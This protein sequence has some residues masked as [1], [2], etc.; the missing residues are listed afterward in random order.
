[1]ANSISQGLRQLEEQIA[2]L[3]SATVDPSVETATRLESLSQIDA[4]RATYEDLQGRTMQ[5]A[6]SATDRV[7]NDLLSSLRDINDQLEELEIRRSSLMDRAEHEVLEKPAF[8]KIQDLFRDSQSIFNTFCQRGQPVSSE[9]LKNILNEFESTLVGRATDLAA[10]ASGQDA[11]DVKSFFEEKEQLHVR[12]FQ[13]KLEE[14]QGASTGDFHGRFQTLLPLLGE[15]SDFNSGHVFISEENHAALQG[16]AARISGELDMLIGMQEE[17]ENSS[18]SSTPVKAALVKAVQ[19][20]DNDTLKAL[21]PQVSREIREAFF[22]KLNELRVAAHIRPLPL[23]T[24]GFLNTGRGS[25][26][27]N[28]NSPELCLQA[29]EA[30]FPADAAQEEGKAEGM[31]EMLEAMKLSMG[32]GPSE[33][34]DTTE[35]ALA[36]ALS[37]SAQISSDQ[38]QLT[39]ALRLVQ[40]ISSE[41]QSEANSAAQA[42]QAASLLAEINRDLAQSKIELTKTLAILLKGL[43]AANL[44]DDVEQ[45]HEQA[46]LIGDADQQTIGM[47]YG[48]L[49]QLHSQNGKYQEFVE[50]GRVAFFGDFPANLQACAATQEERSEVIN[51]ALVKTL[52][53][54]IKEEIQS[55]NTESLNMLLDQLKEIRLNPELP[56]YYYNDVDLENSLQNSLCDAYLLAGFDASSMN[57]AE[58]GRVALRNQEGFSAPAELKLAVVVQLEE[59]LQMLWGV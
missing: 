12:Y 21:F 7:V 26:L 14:M 1:M 19:D 25:I 53:S 36:V 37:L 8:E 42:A 45:L 44:T 20:G 33:M 55:G 38:R 34:P 9:N 29:I 5:E 39:E 54:G 13:T 30:A 6:A 41:Q 47:L 51:R 11:V 50:Y 17:L 24:F 48:L 40:E 49:Y 35:D 18:R 56:G 31:R 32:E 58:F 52:L 43:Q 3:D 15:I 57:H 59:Q 4:L 23:S 22:A 2:V 16:L 10:D 28:H 46:Q 27:E